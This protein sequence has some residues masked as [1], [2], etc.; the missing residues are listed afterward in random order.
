[1]G[2]ERGRRPNFVPAGQ[3]TT[4]AND[5]APPTW[6]LATVAV[7]IA[8]VGLLFWAPGIAYA[9]FPF[10]HS[11][12]FWV[13]LIALPFVVL[14]AAAA[15]SK[16]IDYKRA[17]SWTTT[18]GRVVR[19]ELEV[20]HHRFSGEAET[21]ENV[22]VVDYEF[23]VGG[24]KYLGSRIGIGDDAGGANTEATL[25]RYVVG[26][27]V[28]VYFDPNDPKNCVLE[29]GGP[30]AH[31]DSSAPAEGGGA[32]YSLVHL[33]LIG[34]IVALIVEGPDYFAQRF[35]NGDVDV[36]VF[37]L[38]FG[39]AALILFLAIHRRSKR[40]QGWPS[41]RGTVVKSE[42]EMFRERI[43]GSLTTSYR[44]VVEYSYRVRDR[45]YRSNQI[46]L[47]VTVSGSQAAAAKTAGKY[48]A[49]STVDVHYDPANPGTAALENPTGMTWLILL[50]PAACVALAAYTL[51][52]F[53]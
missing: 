10:A 18:T 36:S 1:M 8:I 2:E 23:T 11:D 33:A 24:R 35:P 22:P 31:A 27:D 32:L 5:G 13:G 16:G 6:A 26:H 12:Y 43:D 21:V 45:D 19:S 25:A 52:V 51:G 41:V 9:I 53:R 38:C 39:L 49:G 28:T 48:R 50:I 14:I 46:K 37:A 34:A 17:Q 15:A 7:T 40:A 29:R 3:E 4:R 47:G 30:L 20:Q 44:P 42:V